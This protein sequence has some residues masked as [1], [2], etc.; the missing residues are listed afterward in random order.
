MFPTSGPGRATVPECSPRRA[1][2]RK[3]GPRRASKSII[4]LKDF[5]FGGAYRVPVLVARPSGQ[6]RAT[7][8]VQPWLP[9]LPALPYCTSLNNKSNLHP[10]IGRMHI[11][12]SVYGHFSFSVYFYFIISI[13]I[14]IIS[15]V[16]HNYCLFSSLL[17]FFITLSICCLHYV[18]TFCAGSS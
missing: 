14:S 11:H 13:S 9:G 1:P 15:I 8:A 18:C 16:I 10:F 7:E 3:S 17:V 12:S 6:A 4:S 2:V 5:F